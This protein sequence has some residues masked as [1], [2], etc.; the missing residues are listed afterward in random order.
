MRMPAHGRRRF[1]DQIGWAGCT[2]E[3][4]LICLT[5]VQATPGMRSDGTALQGPKRA[6]QRVRFAVYASIGFVQL[7]G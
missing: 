6:T 5:M 1:G 4:Q 2:H 7:F 3:R